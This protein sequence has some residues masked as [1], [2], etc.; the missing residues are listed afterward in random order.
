MKNLTAEEKACAKKKQGNIVVVGGKSQEGT[1]P[2]RYYELNSVEMFSL[3]NRTWSKLSPMQQSRS[4]PTA[5]F[6]DG[7]VM[8]TGGHYRSNRNHTRNRIHPYP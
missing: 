3:A 7:R 6:Y 1:F 4:S 5:H 8:V 2:V